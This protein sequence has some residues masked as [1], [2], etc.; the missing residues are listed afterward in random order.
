MEISSERCPIL[1]KLLDEH[2]PG[3][4]QCGEAYRSLRGPT[5]PSPGEIKFPCAMGGALIIG[6]VNDCIPC[7]KRGDS[8]VAVTAALIRSPTEG[9]N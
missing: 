2:L 5:I 6:H 8:W 7:R 1:D 4:S 9:N 3:C